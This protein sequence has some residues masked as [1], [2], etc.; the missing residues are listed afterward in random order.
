LNHKGRRAGIGTAKKAARGGSGGT[1]A[2]I[3]YL[4]R[5]TPELERQFVRGEEGGPKTGIQK[6]YVCI[7]EKG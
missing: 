1:H 6:G 2:V 3:W 7:G 4:L 5:A